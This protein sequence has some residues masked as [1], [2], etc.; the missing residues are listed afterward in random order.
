MNEE[1]FVEQ[2]GQK[3][4]IDVNWW[5]DDNGNVVIDEDSVREQLEQLML[6]MECE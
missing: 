6:N 4:I 2:Y 3:P 1:E 5:V